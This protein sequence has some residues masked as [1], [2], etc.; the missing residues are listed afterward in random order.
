MKK[1]TIEVEQMLNGEMRYKATY[2]PPPNPEDG[3]SRLMSVVTE[4]ELF[5]KR[6]NY[7]LDEKNSEERH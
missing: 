6:N 5:V 2:D 1:V 4:V 3:W 7:G